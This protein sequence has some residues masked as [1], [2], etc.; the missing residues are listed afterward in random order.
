MVEV[1]ASTAPRERKVDC[2]SCRSRETYNWDA[3]CNRCK[4]NPDVG[5]VVLERGRGRG[6]LNWINLGSKT[7]CWE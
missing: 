1:V 2:T 3:V 7:F 4:N 5:S 6:E